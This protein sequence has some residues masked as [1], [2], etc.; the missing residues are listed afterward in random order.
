MVACTERALC[1]VRRLVEK[2]IVSQSPSQTL[3]A[4]FYIPKKKNSR[5]LADWREMPPIHCRGDRSFG[6]RKTLLQLSYL[7]KKI[8]RRGR[9]PKGDS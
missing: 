8:G 5:A 9:V 7:R 1:N 6:R 2:I 3:D 4:I